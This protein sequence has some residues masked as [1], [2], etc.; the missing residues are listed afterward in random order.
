MKPDQ[1]DAPGPRVRPADADIL[2]ATKLL[3]TGQKETLKLT[4]PEEEGEY[5]YVCTYPDHWQVMWGKLIVTKDIDAYLRTK[6][7]NPTAASAAP[8]AA[9]NGDHA[10]ITTRSRQVSAPSTAC[11]CV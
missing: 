2:A 3:E 4:A 11:E 9:G 1:L 7:A 10:H 5:E 8:P 6:P